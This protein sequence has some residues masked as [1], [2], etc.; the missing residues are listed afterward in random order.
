MK[1]YLALK[2]SAGSGKTFALTV[3]YISLLLKGANAS[4]ILTLT[5]TNKA[6]LE[7]SQRI[8]KTLQTLG[9]D[10]AYLN[11]LIRVSNFSKEEILGKK[12]FLIKSFSN[13]TISIFTIDKFVNKILREFC[14]Y[15]G[16]SDDFEIKN[17]DIELLSYR[18]LQS[19]DENSFKDLVDFSNYEKKKFN[20]I[21]EL[22]KSL[23][24]KNENINLI[25]IDSSLINL[26]K[27]IV[28]KQALKIK[29]HFINC[30]SAS[31]SAIKAV[32]FTNFEELFEK[33]W[34]EKDSLFEYSYFKKCAND[35]IN[36][37]FLKLKEEFKNYYKIRASYSLNKIFKLYLEF[38]EYKLNFNKIKNYF[39]FNDI[40]NLVYELLNQKIDKDFLY[41]RLDS[42]YHHILIDEF[43]DTS[44]LQYK[45]LKPLI[46]EILSGDETKFKTF[47]YVG[48]PKQSIYRFRGGKRELF[49]FVLK[50][51][52]IIE[53]EHLNTNYRS[54]QNI[55][56]FVNN[57]F[58]NLVNYDYKKQESIRKDGF[59]EV[60]QDKILQSEDKFSNIA[61]KIDELINNGI[62]PND[63]AI[64]C[65]TNSDVLELFYYLKEKFPA[66][67][68]KTDMTSKLINQQN[69]KAL[70][71]AIKYI[72]FKED[73]YKENFN[74]LLGRNL[75]THFEF[76]FDISQKSMSQILYKVAKY[77]DII[78][79]NI[80][81]LIDIAK[82]YNNI[83]DFVYEVDKL[84]ASIENSEDT[85]LQI[86]TIFKSKGLEFNT[87]IVLD[88]L[89]RKN[90]DKSSLL[91]DYENIELK[92]IFYKI[93]GY[94]NFDLEYK[95]AQE[96]E[97]KLSLD[98]DKNVLYVALT[99]AKNNLI[100]F[101]KEKNSAFDILNLSECKIGNLVQS[102]SLN[103]EKKLDKVSYTPLYLGKQEQKIVNEK[104]VEENELLKARYIGLATHYVL[105][106]MSDFT[107]SSMLYAINLSKARYSNY[108]DE[109]DFVKIE[110]IVKNLVENNFFQELL[111]NSKIVHE[112]VLIYKEE[113]KI[114]D[115]LLF[116]DNCF[117]IIDYKTT[118]QILDKHKTQVA[119]Y[120]KAI[121]DIFVNNNVKAYLFYL[122]EDSLDILEV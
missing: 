89:K 71:N 114:V 110:R 36:Q 102:Q 4:E 70:I 88:R 44:I 29:E 28:F 72:F 91:F 58:L 93:S 39:E 27:D 56:D 63:I 94:E 86:L 118:R 15:I 111:S 84:E 117:Y 19:L 30:S 97:K 8:Y 108:L 115:L 34:I 31:N 23:I 18:F 20:S 32:D 54:C 55:I 52:P 6:A 106:M 100:I 74:A 42:T 38:K 109:I 81:K 66:L 9:D 85:G 53:I 14:G 82:N 87:V 122:K 68:I 96:K 121:S 35:E 99:R 40:S 24:E 45:I 25:D 51:N 1:R 90:F 22:F 103:T 43:Q 120:K 60:I 26:Q 2:A 104:G 113:L 98:D 48:D 49:D 79:E 7:M 92:N 17:D 5:F 76:E 59:V 47:F 119:Y 116:K 21:F 83:V 73:I 105:E 65:Y 37:E 112:Q 78:D 69:V 10:E 11:E 64:L 95:N 107:I 41:F 75:L 12:S 80:V 13:S 50:T 33:T 77:F 16:I 62:N 57:A 101:K 46:E 61:L 3:R 67:K